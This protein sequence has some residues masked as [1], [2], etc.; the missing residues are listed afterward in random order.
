MKKNFLNIVPQEVTDGTE[1][2]IRYKGNDGKYHSIASG[3]DGDAPTLSVEQ[4]TRTVQISLTNP[5]ASPSIADFML[6]YGSMKLTN[7]KILSL[8]YNSSSINKI[9]FDNGVQGPTSYRYNLTSAKVTFENN[10][11]VLDEISRE[12]FNTGNA[13]VIDFFERTVMSIIDELT[14][15]MLYYLMLKAN[16]IIQRSEFTGTEMHLF[17]TAKDG[18]KTDLGVL[19]QIHQ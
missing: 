2:T 9:Y 6:K 1:R 8:R 7:F 15:Y 14:P 16:F 18:T 5:S 17:S 10:G 3:D 13:E 19:N 12:T 4:V 11:S